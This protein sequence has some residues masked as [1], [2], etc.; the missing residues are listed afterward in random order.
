MIARFD[1][2]GSY[3]AISSM[4]RR[5]FTNDYDQAVVRTTSIRIVAF[6]LVEND[7]YRFLGLAESLRDESFTRMLSVYYVHIRPGDAQAWYPQ[8]FFFRMNGYCNC[9]WLLL[10]EMSQRFV[11]SIRDINEDIEEDP[12]VHLTVWQTAK[13]YDPI[14]GRQLAKTTTKFSTLDLL[15]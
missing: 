5:G 14:D 7:A 13:Y 15:L 12:S 4:L 10:R 2:F 8:K 9:D 3:S 1:H 6:G 11:H